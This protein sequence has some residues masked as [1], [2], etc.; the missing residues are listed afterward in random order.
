MEALEAIKQ[1]KARYFRTMDTKDW[2]GMREVFADDAVVDTTSSGGGVV[3]GADEFM[4][5][6]RAALQDVVTV[7]HGHMPEIELTSATTAK[8]IW[9]MQ[10]LLKWPNGSELHGYGHYHETYERIDGGWR[11]KTLKLTRLRADFTAPEAD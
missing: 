1:L 6:L 11:I 3:S 7:H 10:D 5:F 2:E 8:G 4:A 9:A